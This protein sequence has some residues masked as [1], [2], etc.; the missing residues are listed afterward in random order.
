[1]L[2]HVCAAGFAYFSNDRFAKLIL[3]LQKMLLGFPQLMAI[4]ELCWGD[5]PHL[6]EM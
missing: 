6:E 3:T 5:A 4:K 2:T 1:M